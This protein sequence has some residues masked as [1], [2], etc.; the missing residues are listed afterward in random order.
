MTKAQAK[1]VDA[2]IDEVFAAIWSEETR[3]AEEHSR[4]ELQFKMVKLSEVPFDGWVYNHMQAPV[5]IVGPTI[6][7]RRKVTMRND[8]CWMLEDYPVFVVDRAMTRDCDCEDC[9]RFRERNRFIAGILPP[10][11]EELAASL[12]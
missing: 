11:D 3:Q 8:T 7:G 1:R 2:R 10:V 5:G 6:D 12:L 9:E 4:A